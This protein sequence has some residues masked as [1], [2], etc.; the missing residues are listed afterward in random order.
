M[1]IESVEQDFLVNI[2]SRADYSDAPQI[3]FSF[4]PCE[5]DRWKKW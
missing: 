1:H 4:Y 5:K 2:L 3:E